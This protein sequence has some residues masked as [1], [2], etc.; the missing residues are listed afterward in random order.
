[1]L[2]Y[3]QPRQ[4]HKKDQRREIGVGDMRT[5]IARSE[6]TKQSPPINGG[7][8]PVLF[9]LNTSDG[10]FFSFRLQDNRK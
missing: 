6:A 8:F 3:G 10:T 7:D 5:V 9:F 2:P 1:V 4:T